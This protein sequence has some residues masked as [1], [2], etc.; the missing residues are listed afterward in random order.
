MVTFLKSEKM[1]LVPSTEGMGNRKANRKR[2]GKSLFKTFVVDQ[3]CGQVCN[4]TYFRC[5]GQ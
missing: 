3:H 2:K 5:R 1:F 4:H